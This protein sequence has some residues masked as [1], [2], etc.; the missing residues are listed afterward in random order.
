M[1]YSDLAI[2]NNYNIMTANYGRK[3]YYLGGYFI[4]FF[5]INNYFHTHKTNKFI[6]KE[7]RYI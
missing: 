5:E 4:K 3:I 6:E 2:E 1:L 7:K